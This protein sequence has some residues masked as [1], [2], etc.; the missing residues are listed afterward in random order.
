M[1]SF[2]SNRLR[3]RAL[4]GLLITFTASGCVEPFSGSNVQFTLSGAHIPG[5]PSDFGR[6]PPGTHYEFHAFEL[7]KVKWPKMMTTCGVIVDV[8]DGLVEMETASGVT[9]EF[10]PAGATA[11]RDWLNRY[12]EA[13]E[14]EAK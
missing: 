13:K 2:S 14:S 11:L 5:T 7:V 1:A 9:T 10:G 6:P 3:A 8:Q 12:I 4:I